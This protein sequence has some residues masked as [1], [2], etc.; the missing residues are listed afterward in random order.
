MT[1][2]RLHL[3]E[4]MVEAGFLTKTELEA[5]LA[6]HERTGVPI[7]RVLV[8]SGYASAAAVA[9]ALA[10]QHGGVLRT[11]YGVAVGLEA[12]EAGRPPRSGLAEPAGGETLGPPMPALRVVDVR[13]PASPDDHAELEQQRLSF[14]AALSERDEALAE[15]R[16]RLAEHEARVADLMR[17]RAERDEWLDRLQREVAERDRRLAEPDA[18][19]AAADRRA[20]ELEQQLGA[21]TNAYEAAQVE[22]RH[23]REEIALLQQV[24]GRDRGGSPVDSAEPGLRLVEPAAPAEP[25]PTPAVAETDAEPE[26]R[27]LKGPRLGDLLVMKGYIDRDQLATALFESKTTNVMLGRVLLAKGW[28][29]EEELARCLSEQ[30]GIEYVSLM[31]TGVDVS[32][33]RLLP[34]QVG[35]DAAAVPVRR[36]ADGSVTVAFADPTDDGSLTAVETYVADFRPVV[37][38]LSDITSAL[39]SL[40][41]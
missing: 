38:E 26:P 41:A 19:L 10:T 1:E 6:E 4:L 25:E 15:L 11:E 8:E 7:G 29:F 13:Q 34:R 16:G 40:P 5:A 33:A 20:A 24:A 22:L 31:R 14:E 3:G 36:S 32:T 9:T 18:R 35:L 17:Q 2:R 39:R 21:L 27:R 28:I 37:A 30:W 23:A 12:D